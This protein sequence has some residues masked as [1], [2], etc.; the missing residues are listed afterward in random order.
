MGTRHTGN[1]SKGRTVI[2]FPEDKPGKWHCKIYRLSSFPRRRES[3][4]AMDPRLRG[5]DDGIFLPAASPMKNFPMMK[6]VQRKKS[7]YTNLRVQRDIIGVQ[8]ETAW[9]YS[10]RIAFDQ[11]PYVV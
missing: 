9:F 11:Y 2:H 4:T 8:H 7:D 3:T 10:V 5:D 6:V 1:T